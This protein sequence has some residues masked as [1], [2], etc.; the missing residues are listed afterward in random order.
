MSLLPGPWRKV[1]IMSVLVTGLSAFCA[2]G[3]LEPVIVA[4]TRQLF[5]D[6]YVI[7]RLEGL[8]R[9]VHPC[10]KHDNGR[11]CVRGSSRTF[12]IDA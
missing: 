2:S 4:S 8:T 10:T 3:A 11:P 1:A 9:T 7:D 5:F 12:R 6:D